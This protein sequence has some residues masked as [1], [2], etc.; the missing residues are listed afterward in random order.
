MS[1]PRFLAN[2]DP[3]EAIPLGV[4][5]REPA[6]EFLRLRDRGMAGKPDPEVLAYTA[7]NHLLVVSLDVNTMTA[8]A[9][10]LIADGEPMPGIFLAHQR[11][12][13]AAVIDDLILI[14]SSSQAEEWLNQ[15]VFLPLR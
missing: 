1:V 4:T 8:Y 9:S 6:I 7:A 15:I 11:D 10:R 12:S 14:W 3:T 2:H 13:I 5:R